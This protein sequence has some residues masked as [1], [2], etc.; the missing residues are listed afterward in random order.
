MIRSFIAIELEPTLKHAIAGVQDTLKQEFHRLAPGVRVQWVRTDSIHLTLKFLGD[1]EESQVGD[2]LQALQNA[3]GNHTPFSVDVRGFGVFPDVRGPRVLWMGL[4]GHT[5]RLIRLAG[6][7]DAVLI[8]LGFQ[9][10][11]KPY[12]PHLTLA[13][14]KDQPRTIGKALADS[15]LM[16]ESIGLGTLPIQAVALIKSEPTPSGSVYSRL[17]L[18]TFESR[19]V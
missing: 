12:T 7:I 16:R 1:I 13:R 10:E 4:S 5:D 14:I 3:G 19:K 15:G 18:V 9:V 2:I 17:G 8:P 11:R 6:S